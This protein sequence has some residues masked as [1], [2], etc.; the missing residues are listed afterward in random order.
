MVAFEKLMKSFRKKYK[1]SKKLYRLNGFPY[2]LNIWTYE[3]VSTINTDI[4]V[5]EGNGIPRIC[6]WQVVGLKPKFEFFMEIIFSEEISALGLP[7]INYVPPNQ[8]VSSISDNDDVHPEEDSDFEDFTTKPPDI[9]LKRTSRGVNVGTTP[10]KRKR[11]KIAHPHKYDLS[12]ISKA[13]KESDHQP[14]HS[15]QNPEPQQK[16]SENVAGVGVSPNSFNEKINLGSSEIDDLKKFM[17]SYIDQKFGDLDSKVEA[18]EA[19]IKM[20]LNKQTEDVTKNNSDHPIVSPKHTNFATVD[21]SAE[22]VVEGEKQTEDVM[23]VWL[24]L[25]QRPRQQRH[26]PDKKQLSQPLGPWL[27][28]EQRQEAVDSTSSISF[29]LENEAMTL[30]VNPLDAIIP[31][32]LTW[33]DDLLSDSNRVPSKVLQSPYVH[34]FESTDKGKDKIDDHIRPFTPF[35]D[36]RITSPVSPDLIQEFLDW[37]KKGLLKS[38]V[39]KYYCAPVDEYLTTQQH[40]GRGIAIAGYERSIKDI[41]NGFLIPA[42]LPW[43]VV[44]EAYKDKKTCELLGPQHSFTVEYAQEIMQQQSDSLYGTLLWKYGMDKHKDGYVSHSDDPTKSKGGFSKQA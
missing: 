40:I 26:R 30:D 24:E 9:L 14:V 4:D 41:I 21:D 38:H 1:P 33:S 19:L 23:N 3:C 2:A 22:T 6:N 11:L 13:Q 32:Q 34:S 25:E 28:E 36:C 12:R 18:L 44:A 42:S 31:L 7:D 39:N 8:S 5:K 43:H 16:G 37:I 10:P 35:D 29:T 15:F 17:K 27:K 20:E